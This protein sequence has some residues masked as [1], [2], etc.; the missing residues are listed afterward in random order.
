MELDQPETEHPSRMEEDSPELIPSK[1]VQVTDLN[2]HIWYHIASFLTCM[3]LWSLLTGISELKVHFI[4]MRK[5]SKAYRSLWNCL[6]IYKDEDWH[7]DITMFPQNHAGN[8]KHLY[9]NNLSPCSE[10]VNNFCNSLIRNP[11][12]AALG[13]NHFYAEQFIAG[14]R[15]IQSLAL[16]RSKILSHSWALCHLSHLVSL[17]I[18]DAVEFDSRNFLQIVNLIGG[19]GVRR[20]T[21]KLQELYLAYLPNIAL[22]DYG[23]AIARAFPELQKLSVV[24]HKVQYLSH[25]IWWLLYHLKQYCT[26]FECFDCHIHNAALMWAECTPTTPVMYRWDYICKKH[27]VKEYF[28]PVV[29]LGAMPPPVKL[30]PEAWEDITSCGFPGES[31]EANL[32]FMYLSKWAPPIFPNLQDRIMEHAMHA[33][34]YMPRPFSFEGIWHTWWGGYL[35]TI[36]QPMFDRETFDLA[37]EIVL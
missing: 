6:E 33:P 31:I 27:L 7:P 3:D 29:T 14:M 10:A 1:T 24:N 30:G 2:H 17:T 11:I 25:Q 19:R 13:C 36:P 20:S 15:N 18:T 35:N 23:P 8:I 28:L 21:H 22:P 37:G 26:K 12:H 34:V 32:R 5:G 4:G 9:V 16:H